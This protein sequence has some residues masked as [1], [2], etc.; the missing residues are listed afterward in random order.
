[1]A[2]EIIEGTHTLIKEAPTVSEKIELFKSITLT[3]EE[4]RALAQS[5][6]I[7]RYGQDELFP[8]TP[9]QLLEDRRPED[10]GPSLWKT[11]N[12]I[13]ENMMRGGLI[14]NNPAEQAR[15]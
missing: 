13:E 11:F 12:R 10:K 3:Y 4:Q 14:T 1:V 7:A 6:L 15:H 2:H 9:Q 8:I 5:S